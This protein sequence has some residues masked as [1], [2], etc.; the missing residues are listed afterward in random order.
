MGPVS[1]YLATS[2]DALW[3]E[4]IGEGNM[5]HCTDQCLVNARSSAAFILIVLIRDS[6][7]IEQFLTGTGNGTEI[8]FFVSRSSRT[9]INMMG[10]KRRMSKARTH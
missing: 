3:V 4:D 9:A 7:L 8:I 6:C 5:T 1:I 2:G 10:L